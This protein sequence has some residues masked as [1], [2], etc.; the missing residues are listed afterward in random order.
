MPAN[1]II[2][3]PWYERRNLLITICLVLFLIILILLGYYFWYQPKIIEN[4]NQNAENTIT[5]TATFSPTVSVTPTQEAATTK[6]ETITLTSLDAGISAMTYKIQI[7][8]GTT[9]TVDSRKE[10]NQLRA[11]FASPITELGGNNNEF[12]LLLSLLYEGFN[13]D[14]TNAV[15][16]E[17][18]SYTNLYRVKLPEYNNYWFYTNDDIL[19]GDCNAGNTDTTYQ[20]PC[21]GIVIFDKD[22]EIYIHALCEANTEVGL[23]KC[24]AIIDSMTK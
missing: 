8:L 4:N 2:Q 21:G 10:S 16:V 7:P 17:S 23:K 3:K 19:V 20:P 22:K 18:K 13:H 24:D 12:R 6:E 11:L 5:P 9:I 1:Q 15:K 14:F